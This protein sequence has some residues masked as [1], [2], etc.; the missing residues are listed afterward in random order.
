MNE[1]LGDGETRCWAGAR[2]E[3]YPGA[4]AG[5]SQHLIVSQ[6][7]LGQVLNQRPSALPGLHLLIHTGQ[8]A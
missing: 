2:L 6:Q 8:L 7:P 4:V 3:A 5:D 1:V